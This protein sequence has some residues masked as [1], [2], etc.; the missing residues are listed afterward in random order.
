VI[1]SL[2]FSDLKL[3]PHLLSLSGM[4]HARTSHPHAEIHGL[5]LNPLR[6]SFRISDESP[7]A[8]N[9]TMTVLTVG[10]LLVK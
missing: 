8:L 3:C 7:F 1:A 2:C 4:L 9:V 10:K 6:E 5:S